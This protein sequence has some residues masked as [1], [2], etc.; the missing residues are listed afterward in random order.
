MRQRTRI[1]IAIALV[2][3]LAVASLLVAV[4]GNENGGR[5]A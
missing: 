2:A 5:R 1:R 4:L 3:A